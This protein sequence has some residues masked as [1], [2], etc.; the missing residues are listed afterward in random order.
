MKDGRSLVIGEEPPL[1]PSGARDLLPGFRD[2]A[3]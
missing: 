1:I 3:E 2:R